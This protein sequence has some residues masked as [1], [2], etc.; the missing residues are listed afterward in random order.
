MNI[1]TYGSNDRWIAVLYVSK[2]IFFNFVGTS[3]EE[4]KT[5]AITFYERESAK[6][7][8]VMGSSN[9]IPTE[10]RGTSNIGKRWMRSKNGLLERVPAELVDQRLTEGWYFSGPRSK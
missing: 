1:E 7:K 8:R 6:A 5:N 9:N 4:A 3:E 10:G 2:S